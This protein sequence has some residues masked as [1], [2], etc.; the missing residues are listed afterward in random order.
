[1]EMVSVGL[2]K[3][4]RKQ[5]LRQARQAGIEQWLRESGQGQV[6]TRR[7]RRKLLTRLTCKKVN[8]G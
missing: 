2:Q 5:A 8:S 1:M 4:A 6:M 7:E 3:A